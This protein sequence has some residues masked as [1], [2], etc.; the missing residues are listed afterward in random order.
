MSHPS[1]FFA[2]CEDVDTAEIVM[3]RNTTFF[4]S[5]TCH[6]RSFVRPRATQK[7]RCLLTKLIHS[8]P[9]I[10]LMFCTVTSV[11]WYRVS[12]I[13]RTVSSSFALR[14]QPISTVFAPSICVQTDSQGVV[15]CLTGAVERAS[16][17]EDDVRAAKEPERGLVLE[18]E[19][20]CVVCPVVKVV[21]KLDRSLQV[22]LTPQST[23]RLI[24]TIRS[25]KG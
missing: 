10:I 24:W 17:I 21:V 6:V 1:V 3:F 20:E 14:I 25:R 11:A 15:P 23:S 13:G 12:R 9:L 4:P 7:Q 8:G 2:A 18:G 22:L 5:F 19:R 16:A